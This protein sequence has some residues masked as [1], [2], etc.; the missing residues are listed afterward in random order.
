[1]TKKNILITGLKGL[2]GNILIKNLKSKFY[3]YGFDIKT[4]KNKNNNTYFKV[5]I[6]NFNELKKTFTKTKIPQIDVLIHCAADSSVFANWESVLKNNII[7]TKN[8]YEAALL[9]NIPKIIFFSS[10]HITGAYEGNPKVLHNK[11]IKKPIF[12]NDPVRPDSYYG[13]SK[14]FG[15]ILARQFYD[16]HKIKSICLRIGS[17]LA[18]DNPTNDKRLMKIWLSHRDL[19]QLVLKS[20]TTKIPYGVY[21]AIS[22]NKNRYLSIKKTKK[23]LKY[24]PKDNSF[25]LIKN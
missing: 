22:N 24:N 11:K 10:S 14:A 18:D 9:F 16:N 6:S 8:I 5:D 23:E 25:K 20:I 19:I 3:I 13:T 1:M 21:Y 4:K 15:E 2:I 17:V 12:P 7:A